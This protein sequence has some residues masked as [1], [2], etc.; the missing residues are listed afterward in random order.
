MHKKQTM[1]YFILAL[2]VLTLLTITTYSQTAPQYSYIDQVGLEPY[3]AADFGLR[4]KVLTVVVEDY[5]AKSGK[6]S[7]LFMEFGASGKL[8][9][10]KEVMTFMGLETTV[11]RKYFYDANGRLSSYES[12]EFKESDKETSTFTYDDKGNM[13]KKENLFQ[14]KITKTEFEYNAAKR[15]TGVKK[16]HAGQN[17]PYAINRIT[18]DA[19]NR[20][21][22]IAT[23]TTADKSISKS[24]FT[25]AG[26]SKLPATS[27]YEGKLDIIVSDGDASNMEYNTYGDITTFYRSSGGH[28][29]NLKSTT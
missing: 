10:S 24:K 13:V 14:G 6:G 20:I 2:T 15:V 21:T 26:D 9:T 27:V 5:I 25:Y 8:K 1:R 22:E 7:E 19:Q 12:T 3:A 28:K 29:L 17:T 11:N 4:G 16:F 18:Y 23:E